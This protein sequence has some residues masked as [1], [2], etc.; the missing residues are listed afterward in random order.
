PSYSASWTYTFPSSNATYT[1]AA[2]VED[3]AGHKATHTTLFVY[4]TKAASFNIDLPATVEGGATVTIT[5]HATDNLSGIESVTVNGV[6]AKASTSSTAAGIYGIASGTYVATFTAPDISKVATYNIVVYDNAGNEATM[7]RAIYIDATA[8]KIT[9]KFVGTGLTPTTIIEHGKT[10]T[11]YAKD[12]ATLTIIATDD[13]KSTVTLYATVAKIDGATW[14]RNLTAISPT[15][16]STT[17]SE[18]TYTVTAL[19]TDAFGHKTTFDGATV[20]VVIDSTLP[21]AKLSLPSTLNLSNFNTAVATYVATDAHF[22]S[23]TLTINNHGL[24]VGQA[25]VSTPATIALNDNVF[26]LGT[27][28]GTTV[29]ATLTVLDKAGNLKT[30]T[31]S[32]YVDT[33]APTMSVNKTLYQSGGTYYL[34]IQFSEYMRNAT[35]TNLASTDIVFDVNGVYYYLDAEATQ[36]NSYTNNNGRG[37]L[38]ISQLLT[39]SGATTNV[40]PLAGNTVTITLNAKKFVDSCG[41]KLTNIST[42]VTFKNVSSPNPNNK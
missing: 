5:I 33:V 30:Y 7:D 19:A 8:P 38:H 29:T 28:N 24:L 4:D 2:T 20:T 40:L 35:I 3:A 13:S 15:N 12:G 34:D 6:A 10:Y 18:A 9:V 14:T 23:A 41:N 11:V 25:S 26:E 39:T 32:F 31:D 21:T 16:I 36:A 17:L 27:I 22:Y 42:T 1:Y 37:L